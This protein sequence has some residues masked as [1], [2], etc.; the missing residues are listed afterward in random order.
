MDKRDK[1]TRVLMLYLHLLR[2]KVIQ[3]KHYTAEAGITSRTFERDLQT[4]RN[5]LSEEFTGDQVVYDYDQ[6]GYRLEQF[7]QPKELSL[8]EGY[9]LL[10]TLLYDRVLR[11]DELA[12]LADTILAL[13]GQ[14][15]QKILKKMM[16]RE[17]L[18]YK[19]SGYGQAVLKMI[20]DLL[21]IERQ[22]KKILL[23]YQINGEVKAITAIPL[24]LEYGSGGFLLEIV[25][26]ESNA[27][28][29]CEL[30]KICSFSL[31]NERFDLTD[32]MRQT[33]EAMQSAIWDG[34]EKNYR[35][36]RMM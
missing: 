9:V 35:L 12:G 7:K 28:A 32:S 22:Q 24:G 17:I 8:V 18:Q 10:K 6:G 25:L 16:T 29:I 15:D 4:L 5:C 13:L 23:H 31:V 20:Q 21:F 34:R 11:D 3:K 30:S 27:G 19:A 1:G 2:G 14:P 26:E 36:E 33:L